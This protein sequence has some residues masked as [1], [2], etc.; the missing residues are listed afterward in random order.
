MMRRL[1][2]VGV[3]FLLVGGFAILTNSNFTTCAAVLGLFL[4]L[5]AQITEVEKYYAQKN[6]S[7]Q[8]KEILEKA[9]EKKDGNVE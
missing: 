3:G 4:A 1:A 5:D 7:L 6:Y 9:A 2:Y 8:L